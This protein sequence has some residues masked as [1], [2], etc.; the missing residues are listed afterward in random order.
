MTFPENPV[1]F[2]DRHEVEDCLMF[3]VGCVLTFGFFA[4]ILT[5]LAYWSVQ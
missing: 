3:T 4:N 2:R 1:D 5:I